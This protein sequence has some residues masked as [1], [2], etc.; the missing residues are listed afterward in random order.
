MIRRVTR[1]RG[2][3]VEGRRLGLD[4]WVL[5]LLSLAGMFASATVL[6]SYLGEFWSMAA[7]LPIWVVLYLLIHLGRIFL[8]ARHDRA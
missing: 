6:I 7:F 8:E 1:R 5:F 2:G 3:T 4:P